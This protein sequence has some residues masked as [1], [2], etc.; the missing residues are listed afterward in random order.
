MTIERSFQNIP[1]GSLTEADKQTFLV[2]LGWAKADGWEQLLLSKRILIVSEAGG[3][4]THECRAQQ[5]MLWDAG[6]P[7]FFLELATLAQSDVRSML[8]DEEEN[9]FDQWLVSQADVATFFLDSIDELKLSAGTFEQALKRLRKAVARQR[10]GRLRIIITTRPIPFDEHLVQE[11]LPVPP[12]AE[13]EANGDTFAQV[14]MQGRGSKQEPAKNQTA[15]DWRLVALMPLSDEQILQ[16]AQNKGVDDPHVLMA[17]LRRRNAQEFARRP[18]DLIELCADWRD[19]KRIRTHR[20]QVESNIRVKLKARE[21]RPEPAE[22][23]VDKAIDGASRL[24]LSM[25]LTRRLTIRHSADADIGVEEAAFDPAT[26]L[27]DWSPNERKALLERSLFGFASY[28]RVRFHHRSV[29]EYLAAERIRRLREQGMP[30]RSLGHLLFAQAKGRTIVRPSKRPIA[31]WL[32]L[33][34]NTIFEMLR[35]HEPSILLTEGDPESLTLHQRSQ[36]LRAYAKR[37]GKGGWRGLSIPHIQVHRFASRDLAAD[38][39][40]IWAEG[41][42][43]SEVRETLLHLIDMGQ[44]VECSDIAFETVQNTKLSHVERLAAIDALA[45]LND[46]RLKIL[47]HGIQTNS[48]SWSEKFK[49]GVVLRLFPKHLSV[50]QLCRILACMN[51]TSRRVGD[52][53]WFLTRQLTEAD[54]DIK[55]LE[56]LRD[57]L[58]SLVSTGLRWEKNWPHIVSDRSDLSKILAAVCIR[59]I[60]N[61]NVIDWLRSSVLALRLPH[62]E[63]G[64]EEVFGELKQ[65]LAALP[66]SQNA[67]LFW[68]EDA[69]VQSLH[70]IGEPWSRLSQIIIRGSVQINRDRDWDWIRTALADVGLPLEKRAILLQAA[71]RLAPSNEQ[72]CDHILGL[73]VL[74]SDQA[75]LLLQIDNFLKP[76][77]KDEEISRW[78]IESAKRTAQ[79]EQQKAKDHA[80]WV[81]FWG[82]IAEHPE[83]VFSPERVGA[84]VWNLWRAM[85]KAG[86]ESRASGW[87]R[88]FIEANFGKATAD[89]LRLTLMDQWRQDRPTLTS[90]RPADAKNTYFLS[91]QLGLAA[92]Y[93]ESEDPKWAAKLS[94]EEAKLAA[95]Y[96]PIELNGFPPWIEALVKSHPRA[97][98]EVLGEELCIDLTNEPGANWHSMLLQ[99]IS[100]APETVIAVFI[101][102]LRSW[103]D[104]IIQSVPTEKIEGTAQRLQQVVPILRKYC[105]TETRAHLAAIAQKELHSNTPQSLAYVWLPLLIRLDVATG[106][107]ALEERIKEIQPA[108]RSEAVNWTGN[109]FGRSYEG[110]DLSDLQF[111]PSVLLKLMRLVYHHVRPSDD[112]RHEGGYSPD[113]RDDAESARNAIVNTLLKAKGEDGWAAKLE[114]AADPLCKYF[115]DRILALAEEQLA[116]EI[117]ADTFS[118][119]QAVAFD[120]LGEAPPATNEAMFIVM[121]NRLEDIEGLLLMDDSPRDAWALI[122]QERVMRREIARELRRAANGLYKVDQEAATADEKETDIRLRSTASNHEAVIELKLADD[123]TACDLRDT[124]MDQL[125]TK[126]MGAET[127]R[128]GCL[129]VTLSKNKTWDHPNNGSKIDFNELCILLREEAEKITNNLGGTLR[130]HIQPLDLR[131]RLPNEK[132][133]TKRVEKGRRKAKS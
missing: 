77:E 59:G 74:V 91:W 52:V 122:T 127:S 64:H 89:R 113:N 98:D 13:I 99:D 71:V 107:A 20:E 108:Q 11:M 58:S 2:G 67:L 41:I 105:N 73:K 12:I 112:V 72:R 100:H 8:D 49:E 21:D 124:I 18:Q 92:I 130:L 128:S 81:K 54:L 15:A 46:S 88:R 68:T 83:D 94:H 44:V 43:N 26:V 111:T 56:D 86:D 28:G 95:R 14:A 119:T 78:E 82:E 6:Q 76:E 115:K 96:A 7:A 47:V 30:T 109:L 27:S 29:M 10:L 125:I 33:A 42:E 121:K 36:A 79:K 60:K 17:D 55:T 106:L 25:M 23:S 35:D 104:K 87:N 45:S 9:R 118:D 129:M 1:E 131:P 5:K 22:V 39:K 62:P 24:A 132:G 57:G 90:E 50:T 4:K 51:K 16:F 103:F 65:M 117:D 80:S 53:G 97:V 19:L 85:S 93:A 61:G 75:E 116:E 114:M 101:P 120:Q 31:G 38:I 40:S 84:T 133:K 70:A 48:A 110:I 66:A 63:D 32:A 37:F 126:Y 102:R 34:D 3:G 69:F 123:R